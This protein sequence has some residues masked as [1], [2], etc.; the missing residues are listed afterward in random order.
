MQIIY[1]R[2]K[3]E[4][5]NKTRVYIVKFLKIY[6]NQKGTRNKIDNEKTNNKYVGNSNEK[7]ESVT[8][9]CLRKIMYF[10]YQQSAKVIRF[11]NY[12][13]ILVQY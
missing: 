2:I 8:T 11:L 1:Y 3:L 4:I 12:I 7:M 9:N 5:T 6:I 13:K 10:T